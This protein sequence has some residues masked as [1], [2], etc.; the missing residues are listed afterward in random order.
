MTDPFEQHIDTLPGWT[1]MRRLRYPVKMPRGAI[2]LA[3]ALARLRDKDPHPTRGTRARRAAS[4][5]YNE[6]I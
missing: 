6:D 1:D 4:L 2:G 5:W 3:M